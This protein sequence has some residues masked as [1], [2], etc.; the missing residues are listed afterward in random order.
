MPDET[1]KILKEQKI[2]HSSMDLEQGQSN[3]KME[4]II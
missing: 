1:R 3:M 4:N 2:I